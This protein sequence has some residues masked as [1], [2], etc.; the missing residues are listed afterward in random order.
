[1]VQTGFAVSNLNAAL[2]FLEGTL[3]LGVTGRHEGESDYAQGPGNLRDAILRAAWLAIPNTDYLME[4]W[5]FRNPKGPPADTACNNSGS[6][7]FCFMVKDMLAAYRILVDQGVQFVGR[8]T[9]VTAGVNKGGYATYFLGP[10]NI[11]FELFQGRP[12]QVA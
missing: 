1:M 12:T 11:R 2:R 10:D 5:E 3:G 6:G 9:Q 8:P 4:L 7:H